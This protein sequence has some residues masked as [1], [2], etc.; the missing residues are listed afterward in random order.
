VLA[1]SMEVCCIPGVSA[2][3]RLKIKTNLQFINVND[4]KNYSDHQAYIY[5]CLPFLQ[6]NM[7]FPTR[8]LLTKL[9]LILSLN[10]L[11]VFLRSFLVPIS[12]STT[13]ISSHLNCF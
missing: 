12:S 9:T 1:V 4:L 11:L 6:G 3:L 2:A 5:K 8:T 10:C 7:I 13:S